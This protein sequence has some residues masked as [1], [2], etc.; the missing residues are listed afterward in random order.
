[1]SSASNVLLEKPIIAD[2]LFD[3]VT[4]R[5][6]IA[7]GKEYPACDKRRQQGAKEEQ[8]RIHGFTLVAVSAIAVGTDWH[9]DGRT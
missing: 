9:N 1:M 7:G 5:G 8:A 2:D 6:N 4:G 3:G